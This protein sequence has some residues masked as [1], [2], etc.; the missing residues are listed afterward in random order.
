MSDPDCEAVLKKLTILLT[1]LGIAALTA[2]TAWL[3]FGAVL[4]AMQKIGF[5]GFAALLL[6]QLLVDGMLGFAW[7]LACP[8]L[9]LMRTTAARA[10]RDAAGNC[11]PFS[12]LGGMLVGIRATCFEPTPRP[13]RRPR[14]HPVDWPEAVATNL[15]DITTEVLGQIVFIL[16]A[17]FCLIG[18]QGGGKFIW[19]VIG[20]MAILSLGIAGFIYTQQKSGTF[21]HRIAEFF[22][23]HIA[24]SWRDSL[25]DNMDAFQTHLDALWS[26]PARV[27]RGAGMHLVGWLASAGLTLLAFRLLGAQLSYTGAVA[28]EGVVCGV[29]SAGFLVPASLGVQ[30]AAYVALG[31]IFNIDPKIALGLSLLRRGR[32]IALGIPMLLVWQGLEMRRLRTARQA[33]YAVP[34]EPAATDAA[35]T[36]KA[37]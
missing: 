18:H 35:A 26:H 21:I 8:E 12:Q 14:R 17:V 7:Y 36:R 10:L 37:S 28:V 11:L 29:M 3:G 16:L 23:R 1:F 24:D 27:A 15:V 25:V 13:G 31:V 30:E 22:G 19:P 5:S 33:D 9:G 6:G 32:D 34:A 4:D 20:G 2:I